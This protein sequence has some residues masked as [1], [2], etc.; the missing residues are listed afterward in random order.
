[1]EA[2]EKPTRMAVYA[3]ISLLTSSVIS[4]FLY[5]L[6][7]D[8]IFG[9]AFVCGSRNHGVVVQQG[10]TEDASKEREA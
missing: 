4:N 1:M 6:S 5:N 7:R 9:A 10:R 3:Y 8:R 2:R